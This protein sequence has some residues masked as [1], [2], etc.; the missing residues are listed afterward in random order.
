M[1]TFPF[2]STATPSACLGVATDARAAP[3]D[4]NCCALAALR[5]VAQTA[6]VRGDRDVLDERVRRELELRERTHPPP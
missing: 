1:K 2:A 5:S 6:A 3:L 4:E